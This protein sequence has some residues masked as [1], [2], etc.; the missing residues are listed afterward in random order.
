MIAYQ[1]PGYAL[2]NFIMITPAIKK[3]AELQNKPVDVIFRQDFVQQSFIDCPFINIIPAEGTHQVVVNSAMVNLDMP[4]YKYSF[5]RVHNTP[6]TE[7]YH[8]YID[9]PQEYDYSDQDYV[10][11]LNGLAGAGWRGKKEV[12]QDAHEVIKQYS[13]LPIWFTGNQTDLDVNSPWMTEMADKVELNDIRKAIAMV[14][15]ANLIISNDTGLSHAAGALNKDILILWKDTPFTKNLNPGKHTQYAQKEEW[16][17]KIIE[18][19][20]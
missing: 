16:E 19:L 8:T 9:S 3:L 4:D 7:E 20:K 18:Y 2:G 14:R 12:S 17:T 11:V 15:D 13:K 10:L 1:T 6:W 5:Q